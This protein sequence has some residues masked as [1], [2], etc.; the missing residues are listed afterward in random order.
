M[1]T[2]TMNGHDALDWLRETDEARLEELWR[3]VD[4]VRRDSIGDGVRLWGCIGISNVCSRRCTYCGLRVANSELVR[5]RMSRAEI[6]DCADAA[7]GRGYHAVVLQGGEDDETGGEWLAEIIGEIRGRTRLAIV[8]AMGERSAGELQ[9]WRKCGAGR[10]LLR[11]E[12]SDADLYNRIHPLRPDRPARRLAQLGLVRELGFEIGSGIMVGLLGQTWKSVLHDLEQVVEHDLDLIDIGPYV[13]HP[14]TPL[15]QDFLRW[16]P[17]A[18]GQV[19]NTALA[20]RKAAAMARIARPKADL[21]VTAPMSASDPRG[22]EAGLRVGANVL[23]CDLTPP[24]Y[25]RLYEVY[26]GG[27]VPDHDGG[28]VRACRAMAACGR[29]PGP[30]GG[31]SS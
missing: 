6:L 8:L 23:L 22:Y 16:G 24:E 19:P 18:P 2:G 15:G 25:L 13:P 5:Y 21:I 3:R 12:T 9:R 4:T 29:E 17:L 11:F 7:E 10:Y 1:L 30:A 26:P 27:C 20:V 28:W 31:I 14:G